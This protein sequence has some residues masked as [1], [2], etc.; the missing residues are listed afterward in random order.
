MS[1]S[2]QKRQQGFMLVGFLLLVAII[3][4]LVFLAMH[5]YKLDAEV[6][7]KFETRRWN[8]PATVYSRPLE[9][10]PQMPLS[11]KHLKD[12]LHRLNY[13]ETNSQKTG[14]YYKEG[15]TYTIYARKFDYGDGDIDEARVLKITLRDGQIAKLQSTIA[16]NKARLEPIEMG[17]IYPENNE[18]REVLKKEDVPKPL[19]DAL[20]ATEDR[21]FYEHHGVSVRGIARAIVS[22]ITGGARQGGSTIT[23]QLIKN[24][25]LN[26]DRTLKRKANEAL[27]ALLLER[28]YAKDDILIAYLNEINL[29]QNGN[30]S[31]N[32]FAVASRFYFNKPLSELRLD[33][34]ALL[35]G[36][37][38]GSS[39]YNPRKYP[40]RTKDRRD[41]VLHNML[42][43]GKITQEQHDEAV[44]HDMDIADKPMLAKRHFPD[45]FDVV[46]RDL[47]TYYQ[48][49]DLMSAG[50][51]IISTLD[52]IAQTSADNAMTAQLAKLKKTSKATQ[53]LQGALVSADPQTGELVAI[54]GSA[55]EFTGFNR[56]VDAKR[57]VGSLLKPV[58]Y[59]TALQSGKYNLA[60]A[61]NDEPVAYPSGGKSW[62]PKNYGGKSHGE[63]PLMTALANSYNQSAVN[64]GM[65][66]ELKNFHGQLRQFGIEAEISPYPSVLLGAMDLSPMNMLGMYQIFASGGYHAP[67]HS[68]RQIISE[69]GQVLKRTDDDRKVQRFKPEHMYLINHAMTEVI[70]NGTAKKALSLGE[71]LNL[72]GKT[73]T[74]NDARDAWFAG[75]SGNYVSVVWVGR[76]DNKPIGL[77]GGTGALP[78]WVDYMSRLNLT[79]NHFETPDKVTWAW[80]DN[81]TGLLSKE[82]CPNAVY[83]PVL[84]EFMPQQGTDCYYETQVSEFQSQ[85]TQV[86]DGDDDSQTEEEFVPDEGVHYGE[87][88]EYS[89]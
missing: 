34:Y 80:L 56:A 3:V 67:I 53:N 38:K 86:V 2:L 85:S 51:R 12:W 44:A 18:D 46:R 4:G 11:D 84:N 6:V 19:V 35:V 17:R 70:K 27:M 33:Q 43:M 41:T 50:L 7:G 78:I 21:L 28:H 63:V 48:E 29:G 69:T 61:V 20:I 42:V 60:S 83:L 9:L 24:F 65:D 58:I 62:T 22:N 37:A 79:P 47:K 82:G 26:S 40:E 25:Y 8:I 5:A 31:V 88:T 76:D 64:V 13:S 45:F 75:Y 16:Q 57:Q 49:K 30:V 10:L 87:P 39:Y 81:G 54:V 36:I 66:M 1:G 77:T 59:L 15:N 68:V 52:P 14:T 55:G 74:T 89:E 71:H 72:A 23:Q 32:G 73:G